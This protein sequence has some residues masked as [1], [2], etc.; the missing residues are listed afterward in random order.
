MKAFVLGMKGGSQQRRCNL[1]LYAVCFFVFGPLPCI[2]KVTTGGSIGWYNAFST[3]QLTKKIGLH[4]EYQW[5]RFHTI[6][7]PQQNLLRAGINFHLR[8]SVLL[9]GGYAW[10]ETFAYGEIPLNAYGKTFSEHRIFQMLQL[11]R[12]MEK[13]IF[14]HRFMLEQRFVGQYRTAASSKEDMRITKHR[15]RYMGRVQCPLFPKSTSGSLPYLALYDEVFWGMG[16]KKS[17]YVFDQNRLGILLGKTINRMLRI[18]LGYLNQVIRYGR[19]I[20]GFRAFQINHG[21]MMNMIFTIDLTAN[22]KP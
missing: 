22:D 3:L 2:S 20:N 15:F 6:T 11:Q 12:K 16:D 10:I 5:R 1:L 13:A 18:E 7:H 8:P 4:A 17:D 21:I 9:R 14:L 19:T